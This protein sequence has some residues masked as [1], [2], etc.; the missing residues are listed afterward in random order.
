MNQLNKLKNKVLSSNKSKYTFFTSL[1][2]FCK[3]FSCL[4]ELL[5]R[6]FEV[7]DSEGKIKYTVYQKPLKLNQLSILMEEYVNLKKLEAE[8]QKEAVNKNKVRK[9]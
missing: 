9:R 3:E 7:R 2:E 6:E 1:V 8:A 5:G 4:S